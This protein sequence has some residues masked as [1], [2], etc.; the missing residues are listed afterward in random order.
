MPRLLAAALALAALSC[1]EPAPAGPAGAAA[2]SD[3]FQDAIWDDGN[4]EVAGYEVQEPRY[5]TMRRGWATLI[6]VKETFDADALIKADGPVAPAHTVEVLK[7]N[8]VRTTP[9]GVYTYRQMGSVFVERASLRPLKLVTS[10]QEWCG[11][12]H[13]RM[14]IRSP[15]PTLHT[16]SYFGAEGQRAFPIALDERTVLQDALPLWLRGLALTRPGAR[17]IRLVPEQLSSHTRAPEIA[18]ATVTVGA[19]VPVE[20]PAGAFEAIPVEVAHAGGTDVFHY[21]A[22]PPHTLVR[23]DRADGGFY[24]L[25]W[26]E[27]A[28]YWRMNGEEHEGSLGVSP[29]AA[30]AAGWTREAN[31]LD[32]PADTDPAANADPAADADSAADTDP[33]ADVDSAA[34]ADSEAGAE[35]DSEAGAEAG[36]EAGSAAD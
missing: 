16:S 30:L 4:A 33:A 36:A 3:A 19:P 13:T 27:R 8:H 34:D 31:A 1:E 10:S 5:G 22:T 18:E 23:W 6:V 24:R 32:A 2:E 9:T 15:R 28:P 14:E 7:L 25:A 20:V 17:T 11:I 29:E 35:A 26:V 12:T 21:D